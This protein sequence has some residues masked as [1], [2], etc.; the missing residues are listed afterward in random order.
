MKHPLH[1]KAHIHQNEELKQ[2]QLI[3]CLPSMQQAIALLKAP[4]M[5][6]SAIIEEAIENNPL[7]EYSSEE[8]IGDTP[9]SPLEKEEREEEGIESSDIGE[10]SFEDTDFSVLKQLDE[11]FK[12][13]ERGEEFSPTTQNDLKR[14]EYLES[15]IQT[16]T[17]LSAYL[18]SQVEESFDQEEDFKIAEILIGTINSS[19]LLET[20]IDELELLFGFKKEI[21]EKTLRKMQQFDPP[22]VFARSLQE[23]CLLQLERKGLVKAISYKVISQHFEDLIHNRIPTIQKA[24]K[25]KNEE[26]QEALF[27][28]AK[29]EFHPGAYLESEPI[30][31]IT[32]DASLKLEGERWIIDINKESIPSLRLNRKYLRML[33]N[34]GVSSEAKEYIKR[35]LLSAKSF[36]K[37]I[38]L[39]NDT[40][41]RIVEELKK[42][43]LR[44]FS[45]TN[46]ELTPMTMKEIAESLKLHES[47]I[48]RACAGKYLD[49]PRGLKPFSFFFT[50]AYVTKKGGGSLAVHSA[51]NDS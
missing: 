4:V 30:Q 42:R 35:H 19:G 36:V 3:M 22:G 29:L 44:F 6:L 1:L 47:T 26:I 21:V 27:Q 7:L 45:S 38:Y 5:E 33:E 39:R 48:A 11:D 37:S 50:N 46:G 23:C 40:L 49:S 17:N 20:P 16:K 10:L 18:K 2:T 41:F 43:Q 9:L 25:C 51:S 24:L 14:R 12:D 13:Q 32:P 28:I 15:S 34:P 31:P 8:I